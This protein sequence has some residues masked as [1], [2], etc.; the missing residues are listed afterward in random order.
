MEVE[1]GMRGTLTLTWFRK[2]P[3]DFGS[4][5]PGAQRRG[6]RRAMTLGI[7]GPVPVR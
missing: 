5:V 3:L 4:Q 6:K 1:D 7:V 2:K